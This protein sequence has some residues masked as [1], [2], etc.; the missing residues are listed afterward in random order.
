MAS[1]S[2][3]WRAFDHHSTQYGIACWSD[4]ACPFFLRITSFPRMP[5]PMIWRPKVW[6]LDFH[7]LPVLSVLLARRETVHY[8]R[9][10][11]QL[12]QTRTL[13]STN[14]TS[15]GCRSPP[16]ISPVWRRRGVRVT[17]T[18][19]PAVPPE[20]L[21]P[22]TAC[23]TNS[24]SLPLSRLASICPVHTRAFKPILRYPY[25]NRA[26]SCYSEWAFLR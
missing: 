2:G 24:T 21:Q 23:S 16:S 18:V 11:P 12:S 15:C 8:S 1:L 14:S 19:H 9:S 7:R 20:T 13:I 5:K 25:R 3:D 17:G 4:N 22:E 10:D 26:A 6:C